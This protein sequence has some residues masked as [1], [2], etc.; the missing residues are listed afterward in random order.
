MGNLKIG[1]KVVKRVDGTRWSSRFFATDSSTKS[2]KEIQKSLLDIA[3]NPSEKSEV[4]CEAKGLM[5]HLDRFEFAFMSVFWNAVL[6]RFHTTSKQLQS[7]RADL[8]LV[9]HL[10]TSLTEFISS[11]RNDEMFNQFLNEAKILTDGN[12]NYEPEN[13]RRK[14]RKLLPGESR[15]N[16]PEFGRRDNL[17]I[18]TYFAIL[19]RIGS[20]LKK[21]QLTYSTVVDRFDFLFKLNQ[22]KPEEIIKKAE[23]LQQ[24]YAD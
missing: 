2:W 21:R 3:D 4:R 7:E 22:L 17:R 18:N 11:L 8:N 6:Q 16:E 12:E 10:Y 23:N 20:E 9:N 5:K 13:K 24:I 14:I 19:D 1:Q 15:E